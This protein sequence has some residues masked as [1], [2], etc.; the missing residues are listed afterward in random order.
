MAHLLKNLNSLSKQIGF[1]KNHSLHIGN[2]EILSNQFWNFCILIRLCSSEI[3]QKSCSI[4]KR[5][6]EKTHHFCTSKKSWRSSWWANYSGNTKKIE[7]SPR[8]ECKLIIHMV[9]DFHFYILIEY[10]QGCIESPGQESVRAVCWHCLLFYWT[11]P[12]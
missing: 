4:A 5:F 2:F 8:L 12:V 9:L 6:Q 11:I 3:C 1:H 10:C 7:L